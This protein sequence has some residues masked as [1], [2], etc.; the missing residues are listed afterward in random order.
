MALQLR[1]KVEKEKTSTSKPGKYKRKRNVFGKTLTRFGLI[2]TVVGLVLA[3]AFVKVFFT[4]KQNKD[5]KKINQ[6]LKEV[7]KQISD[8]KKII[9]GKTETYVNVGELIATLPASFD[10]QATSLD[11]DRMI[12]LSGLSESKTKTRKMNP[13]D[14]LPFEITD[15]SVKPY[16]TNVKAVQIDMSLEGKNDEIYLLIDFINY[17]TEYSHEYFYYIDSISYTEDRALTNTCTV[18]LKLYTFYNDIELSPVTP[19]DNTTNT[20]TTTNK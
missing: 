19:T 15:T 17:L 13:V 5:Q 9:D 11:L 8:Y 16:M 12:I 4:L 10:R 2:G 7:E 14:T 18:D 3:F 6:D 20:T 1:N